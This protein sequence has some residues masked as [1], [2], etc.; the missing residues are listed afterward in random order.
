MKKF[1]LSFLVLCASLFT[2]SSCSK[3]MSYLDDVDDYVEYTYYDSLLGTP[4]IFN[5]LEAYYVGWKYGY[6][7]TFTKVPDY[8]REYIRQYPEKHYFYKKW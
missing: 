7:Y 4:V 2:F 1:V 3:D 5:G 6:G 8:K